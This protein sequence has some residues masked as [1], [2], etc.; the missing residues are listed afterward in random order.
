MAPSKA[1]HECKISEG[2]FLGCYTLFVC[3]K[4]LCMGADNVS[5]VNNYKIL[6]G[7]KMK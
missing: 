5:T 2:L 7:N 3:S 4:E 1:R 6:K